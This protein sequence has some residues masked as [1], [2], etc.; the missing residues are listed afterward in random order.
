MPNRRVAQRAAVVHRPANR[1]QHVAPRL[2]PILQP[3]IY[4]RQSNSTK[5]N[6][7]Q[8]KVTQQQL[9]HLSTQAIRNK[10]YITHVTKTRLI[11][12]VLSRLF[13]IH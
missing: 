12:S 11:S 10:S 6:K 7:H 4:S 5:E 1:T 8:R 9:P 2:L 3:P 13:T